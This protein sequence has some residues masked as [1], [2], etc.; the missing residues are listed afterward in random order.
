MLRG[1]G[2]NSYRGSARWS[3]NVAR[4]GMV[5][6]MTMNS[7]ELGDQATLWIGPSPRSTRDSWAPEVSIW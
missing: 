6:W 4:E 5:P 2:G 3:N 7:R 1:A